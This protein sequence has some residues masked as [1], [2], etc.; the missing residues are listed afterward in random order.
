VAVAALS[1]EASR[2]RRGI[3]EA[4]RGTPKSACTGALCIRADR[5]GVERALVH[6]ELGLGVTMLS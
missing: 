1:F 4:L 6:G 3:V 5:G 2:L